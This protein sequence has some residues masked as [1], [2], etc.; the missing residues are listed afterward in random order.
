MKK[1]LLVNDMNCGHCEARITKGLTEAGI[2][3]SI[4]LDKKEVSVK[5]D[6]SDD[7]LIDLIKEIGYTV[8]EVK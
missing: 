4:N 8:S 2:E 1:V 7:K 3:A 5:S 6:L